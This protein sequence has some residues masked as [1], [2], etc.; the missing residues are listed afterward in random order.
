MAANEGFKLRIINIQAAFLQAKELERE[1]YMPP[2]KYVRTE[3][4]IWKL[5]KPFYSS[6]N[7]SRKFWLRVKTFLGKMGLRK[8][9]GDEDLYI[10]NNEDGN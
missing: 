8:L 5:K 1:K 4:M 2:P 7:T 3:G 6:S 10:K 9:D